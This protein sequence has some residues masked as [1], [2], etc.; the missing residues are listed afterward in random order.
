[1]LEEQSIRF[2]EKEVPFLLNLIKMTKDWFEC[3]CIAGIKEK[4]KRKREER[5]KRSAP[6]PKADRQEREQLYEFFKKLRLRMVPQVREAVENKQVA[7]LKEAQTIQELDYDDFDL[8]ANRLVP[9]KNNPL[10]QR[11]SL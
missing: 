10:P 6:P 3:N 7:L 8:S 1:L 11:F 5:A 4:K 2:I 9:G